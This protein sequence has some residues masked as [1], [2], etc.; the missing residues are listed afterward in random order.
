MHFCPK[1]ALR[2][3]TS[4]SI[5]SSKLVVGLKDGICQL[6]RC[7]NCWTG[8][9]LV[10]S[11]PHCF[12]VWSNGEIYTWI[13]QLGPFWSLNL[14]ASKLW[15]CASMQQKATVSWICLHSWGGIHNK[16]TNSDAQI[17]IRGSTPLNYRLRRGFK[18]IERF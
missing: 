4:M 17:R 12:I 5:S 10:F 3:P 15:V 16:M 14:N 11:T 1:A 6:F 7:S 18:A 2:P 8:I 13:G 9:F